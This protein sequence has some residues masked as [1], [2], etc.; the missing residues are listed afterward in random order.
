MTASLG[1]CI[2]HRDDITLR[3]AI[4]SLCMACSSGSGTENQEEDQ[5]HQEEEEDEVVTPKSSSIS[6]ESETYRSSSGN[7]FTSYRDRAASILD[8]VADHLNANM[9]A[10]I[11]V[12]TAPGQTSMPSPTA[13]QEPTAQATQMQTPTG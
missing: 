10:E 9:H 1:I 8:I 4:S 6:Y 7:S 12:Q 3:R 2:S 5:E 11:A 13:P